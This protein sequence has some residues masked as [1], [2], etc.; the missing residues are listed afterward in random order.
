MR[1]PNAAKGVKNIFTAQILQ[2]IGSICEIIGLVIVISGGAT[3]ILSKGS[4]AGLVAALSQMAG[5]S[6]FLIAFSVLALIAFIMQIVGI[7]NA[8]KDEESFKSALICLIIGIIAPIVGALFARVS[9]VIMSLCSSVGNLMGLFVTIFIITGIIKLADQLNNGEVSTKGSNILKII[10]VI[11][12]LS[13]IL[14]IVSSFMLTN[15]AIL[16]IAMILLAISL[17]LSL[18]QYIMF[19]TLLS[20]AKKMLNEG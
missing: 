17:V 7:V 18:I 8:K 20:Q 9:P 10:I 1:F 5:A 14:S 11:A 6:I 4:D 2:L 12:G 13:L 16:V 19:L 15:P 3:A